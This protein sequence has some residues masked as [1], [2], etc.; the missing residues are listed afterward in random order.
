MT[1]I[2]ILAA[3]LFERVLGQLPGWGDA[4]LMP[5]LLRSV[6]RLLPWPPMW[7]HPGIL[8]LWIALPVWLVCELLSGIPSP[9]LQ[10]L[11][12][13]GVLL[14]CLGPRDLAEDI[15]RLQ[16]AHEAGDQATERRLM[17]ALRWD[18][19]Q[20][21]PS[22]RSLLGSLFIQSHERLFGVL[23]GFLAFGAA[24][25]L[26]Y[27]LISRLP[28]LLLQHQGESPAQQWADRL[29][30]V[31]AFV[32]AR[33]T[34]LL[35]GLAGS[36]DDALR[37]WRRLGEEQQVWHARTWI[38]LSEVSAASVMR[39]EGDGGPAVPGR[40][41]DCLDEVLRMQWRA[42]LILLAVFA[43]GSTGSML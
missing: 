7:R 3:I 32:P 11:L 1:L 38:L 42:L 25:A 5:W 6:E 31:V 23:L 22:H 10:V 17:Q 43:V 28:L 40:L 24:G 21:T 29:H 39:E 16:A 41:D 33:V 2:G 15:H 30:Q 12:S 36:L 35:F 18:A 8:L 13:A 37:C 4:R 19:P 26:A 20:P 14:L 27:R 9:V 34:A